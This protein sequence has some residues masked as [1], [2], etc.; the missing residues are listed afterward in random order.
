MQAS[1][2]MPKRERKT[3]HR[4]EFQA[5]VD[6]L[7][8]AREEADVSQRAVSRAMGV[9]ESVYGSIERRERILDM[10]EFLD[11]ADAIGVDPVELFTRYVQ[12]V[13]KGKK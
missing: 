7:K 5:L 1:Q 10:V 4:R 8:A 12:A 11:I 13:R 6:T 3:L 9:V 2:T